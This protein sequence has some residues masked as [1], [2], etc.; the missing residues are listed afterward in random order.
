MQSTGRPEGL[1]NGD[2]GEPHR[3]RLF[4]SLFDDL[5]SYA[6]VLEKEVRV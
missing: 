4:D 6:Q 2:K 3:A 1:A 5:C